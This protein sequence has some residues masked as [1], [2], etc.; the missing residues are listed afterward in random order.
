M[1]IAFEPYKKVTFQ[2]HLVYKS[3]EEFV[4]AIGMANPPGIP[5]QGRLNWAN[6]VL[7]RF[8][9]HI[10][11]EALSKEMLSGHVVFDHIECAPMTTFVSELKIAERPLVSIYVVDVSKHVVFEP[12]TAWIKEN[13]FK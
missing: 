1:E 11:S 4:N 10:P 2:S 7:F 8:F 6:G 9:N 5:G 12:L 13:L 3:A